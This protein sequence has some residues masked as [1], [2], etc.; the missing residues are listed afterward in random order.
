M[1]LSSEMTES[2]IKAMQLVEQIGNRLAARH[3]E[4]AVLYERDENPLTY[5]EIA[6][7]YL[8]EKAASFPGVASKAV[9]HAI[10]RLVPKVRRDEIR[11]ERSAERL[12]ELFGGF[13]SETFK[14]HCRNAANRRHDE[15]LGIGVD[16]A[17]MLRGKGRIAWADEERAD[18]IGM[19]DIPEYQ[20]KVAPHIGAP[21]YE[22]IA[23]A[24]NDK[25][26][27]GKEVRYHNSVASIVRGSR[28]SKK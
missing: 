7:E 9:G 24:L 10:R 25:Y 19:T 14:A 18:A 20:R 23:L 28:R 22:A 1:L 21:N 5:L 17:A 3:P 13:D 11:A 27:D 2:Q 15:K 4:I 6:E 16:V 12:E 26:H 8:P